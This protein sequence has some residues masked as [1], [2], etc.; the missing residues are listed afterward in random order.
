MTKLNKLNS[1]YEW[2]EKNDEKSYDQYDY[3]GSKF[4][5]FSKRIYYKNKFIGSPFVAT[6]FIL[7][8]F[9]PWTKKLL[10]KKKDVFP[11]AKAH[12]IL[13]YLNRFK[14]TKNT[15]LLNKAISISDSLINDSIPTK[16]GIGWGYPFNWMTTR[17]LLESGVPLITTTPYCLEAFIEI[18]K[19]TKDEK[20]KEIISKINNFCKN[21][22]SFVT[23]EQ[24]KASS[25]SPVDNSVIV[26][27]SAYRAYSLIIAGDLLDDEESIKIGEE[28]INF[29][30]G[31]QNTDGSWYYGFDHS[32]DNFIDNFHT[33]FVLKNL[34][35]S[36][37]INKNLKL[38][39]TIEKGM[40]YYFQ[41]LFDGNYTIPFSHN[42]RIQ[43]VNFE[44]YDTAEFINLLALQIDNSTYKNEIFKI[45]SKIF[46]EFYLNKGYF[47]TRRYKFSIYNKIPYLR[48]PQS[49][50]F[51]YLSNIEFQCVELLE[52]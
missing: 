12:L 38:G 50:L 6:I 36:N 41:K 51:N 14:N 10:L 39:K 29:V 19:I 21:D 8:I 25:Y 11:I 31:V 35:K 23:H 44:M 16:T 42:K 3:W 49:Q 43:L 40:N 13:G 52:Q 2:I 7:D 33:C 15:N 32:N 28:L 22:L 45:L 4:G 17:G 1:F 26:N 47:I 24:Y 46:D 34:I 20:Y 48:W 9:F 30:V 37:S 27:A 18:Y 5:I